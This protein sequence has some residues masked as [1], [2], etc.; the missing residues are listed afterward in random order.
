MDPKLDGVFPIE[1]AMKC[2]HIGLLCIQ[3][4]AIK[5][6]SMATILL[7]L[8][9]HHVDLAEPEPPLKGPS[10]INSHRFARNE[11]QIYSNEFS[12]YFE[13]MTEIYIL[14][15]GCLCYFRL[16][17]LVATVTVSAIVDQLILF[18]YYMYIAKYNQ[19]RF[20]LIHL[21]H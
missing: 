16:I 5:R 9:G 14:D 7:A 13:D 8:N 1:E 20:C 15:R 12:S 18:A 6:P 2:I 3:E 21:N 19:R 17:F 10:T 4:D 11:R